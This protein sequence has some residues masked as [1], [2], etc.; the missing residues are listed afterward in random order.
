M[1][2]PRQHPDENS[3]CLQ[4]FYWIYI[5]LYGAGAGTPACRSASG[6]LQLA[7]VDVITSH[8]GG[9]QTGT[10][11]D[12]GRTMAPLIVD[13]EARRRDNTDIT[14]LGLDGLQVVVHPFPELSLAVRGFGLIEAWELHIHIHD[15]PA[16]RMLWRRNRFHYPYLTGLPLIFWVPVGPVIQVHHREFGITRGAGIPGLTSR[17]SHRKDPAL[18]QK[19]VFGVPAWVGV[20]NLDIVVKLVGAANRV[21][22]GPS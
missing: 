16:V 20:E 11:E 13:G 4:H 18:A 15:L 9:I 1:Y 2:R 14:I 8:T 12:E 17:V 7:Q 5:A 21:H 22:P 10:A 19:L 3:C 6:S